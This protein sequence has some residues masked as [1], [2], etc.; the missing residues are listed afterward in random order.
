MYVGPGKY[1]AYLRLDIF[2]MKLETWF[3]I[4]ILGRTRKKPRMLK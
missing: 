3:S 2:P 4:N 1:Q